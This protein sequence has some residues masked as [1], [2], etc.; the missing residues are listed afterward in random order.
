MAVTGADRSRKHYHAHPEYK[1]RK[2]EAQRIRAAR[3]RAITDAC[4]RTPCADCG[5][6][7]PP[8]A[9]DFDHTGTDKLWDV[10]RRI[11]RVSDA[12]LLAEIAKCDVVCAVCHR[13][14]TQGR[15]LV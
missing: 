14:R 2:A 8:V 7:Y 1:V 6:T 12:T 3:Q 5:N 11:G 13:I 4:K 15:R 9:M 10:S